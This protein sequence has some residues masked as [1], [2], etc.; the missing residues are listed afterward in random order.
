MWRENQQRKLKESCDAPHLCDDI[1]LDLLKRKW[2]FHIILVL[3]F[4]CW[5]IFL[6]LSVIWAS[7]FPPSASVHESVVCLG[8]V[9]LHSTSP[10]E[11][12]WFWQL[13]DF[14]LSVSNRSSCPP[15]GLHCW[16]SFCLVWSSEIWSSVF[17]L[18]GSSGI[19]IDTISIFCKEQLH[20]ILDVFMETASK[21]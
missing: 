18:T 17:F 6:F 20:Q 4:L 11:S 10:A 2:H 15:S 16:D 1:I 3:V 7:L 9:W 13:P 5:F 14:P 21:L 19:V 8:C 12:C